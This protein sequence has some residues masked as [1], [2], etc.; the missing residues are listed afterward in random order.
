MFCPIE[1]CQAAPGEPCRDSK[2]PID[3]GLHHLGRYQ[4]RAHVI[5]RH[6]RRRRPDGMNYEVL[7]AAP[8]DVPKLIARFTHGGDAFTYAAEIKRR[9]EDGGTLVN[10][11][12]TGI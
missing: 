1:T 11:Y 2:G 5:A 12:S 6:V 7:T 8:G 10:L 9:V 3:G 4:D